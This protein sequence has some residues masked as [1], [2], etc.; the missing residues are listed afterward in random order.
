[1]PSGHRGLSIGDRPW[2]TVFSF[3]MLDSIR[4]MG[5]AAQLARYITPPAAEETSNA[6]TASTLLKPASSPESVPYTFS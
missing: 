2:I 5:V 6:R 4:G 1:M 3:I